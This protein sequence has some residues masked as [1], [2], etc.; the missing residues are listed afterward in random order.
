MSRIVAWTGHRPDIFR[1]PAGARALVE[2]EARVQKEAGATAFLVGGQRGVDTWAALAAIDLAVAFSVILPLDPV[3]F[4]RDWVE[5]DRRA[6]HDTLGLA[7]AVRVAAGYSVRNFELATGAQL[8]IAV[9][10][11]TGG[12]GTAETIDFARQAGTRLREILLEP[13]PT[14]GSVRGRGI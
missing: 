12:G 13:S 5:S 4:A 3:E 10:T 14:A 9:W 1:D 7:T 6:L 11:A 2:A 8:L